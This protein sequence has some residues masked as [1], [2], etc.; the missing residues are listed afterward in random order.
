[1]SASLTAHLGMIVG[2]LIVVFVQVALGLALWWHLKETSRPVE[3]TDTEL[4]L[5]IHRRSRGRD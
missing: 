1:M 5:D 2:V 4:L 3:G